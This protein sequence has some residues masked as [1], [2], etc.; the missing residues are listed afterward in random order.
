MTIRFYTHAAELTGAADGALK[1]GRFEVLLVA[2][3]K[4][5]GKKKWAK[6]EFEV[7]GVTEAGVEAFA[8]KAA[9]TIAA[10]SMGVLAKVT[11]ILGHY[12]ND[13]IP[14]V[15][16][17]NLRLSGSI[18]VSNGCEPAS[19][20]ILSQKIRI[21]WPKDDVTRADMKL[22]G[23]SQEVDGAGFAGFGKIR[24]TSDQKTAL[25]AYYTNEAVGAQIK[26]YER[27][28]NFALITN[29]AGPGVDGTDPVLGE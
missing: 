20:K 16:A 8:V 25:A 22:L 4:A 26:D 29:D 5:C 3:D 7:V 21:P 9:E 28:S 2:I 11:K 23:S 18:I 12:R 15:V 19:P 6:T 10:M 13:E 24:W 14:D 17:S 1:A 27:L